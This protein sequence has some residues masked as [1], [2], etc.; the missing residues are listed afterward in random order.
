MNKFVFVAIFTFSLCATLSDKLA[1]QKFQQYVVDFDK[2]YDTAEEYLERFRIFKENIESMETHETWVEGPNIFTDMTREEFEKKYLNLDLSFKAYDVKRPLVAPKLTQAPEYFNWV[3]KGAYGPVK[4]QSVCGSCWAFATV[5]YLEGLYF[6]KHGE[7]KR[8]S[9]QQLVDCDT[10]DKGCNGGNSANAFTWI[11]DNGGLNLEEDYPYT[12]AKSTCK[13]IPSKYA[14]KVNGFDMIISEDEDEMRDYLFETA[15]ISVM[16]NAQPLFW[17]N[18]G[19]IDVPDSKCDPSILNHAVVL[20]GY[21]VDENGL[22]YWIVRN[23]WGRR[24][25]ENGYFR[26]ARGKGTC[27]INK[28]GFIAFIE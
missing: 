21:G 27:G 3:E 12:V 1:F 23:S 9:E 28:F 16:L 22:D 14:I 18:E 11:K 17:Y 7:A 20:V 26:I 13:S 15:P 25:G 4:D 2:K 6:S 19:I 24:W 10:I 5:G 8:F